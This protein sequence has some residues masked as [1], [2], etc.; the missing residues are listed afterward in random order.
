MVKLWL[1]LEE[2]TCCW[3]ADVDEVVLSMVVDDDSKILPRSVN[4][5]EVELVEIDE[6]VVAECPDSEISEELGL[7]STLLDWLYW[8]TAVAEL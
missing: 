5:L 4:D 6:T 3:A 1:L 8:S 7:L 2:D